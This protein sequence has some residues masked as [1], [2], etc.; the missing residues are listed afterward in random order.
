M[1]TARAVVYLVFACG[2]SGAVAQIPFQTSLHRT[3][4]GKSTWYNAEN[5][6]FETLTGVPIEQMGCRDCHGPTDA[7]GQP[8]PPDYTA[9]CL[10]CHDTAGGVTVAQCLSCHSR[11]GYEINLL[12]F[13]DVHRE[14]G[15]RCWDCHG[16]A[17]LHGDGTE[18]SSMLEPGAIKAECDDCHNGTVM[19]VPHSSPF[20]VNLHDGKLHCTAC[21]AKSV[22]SCYNCHLESQVQAHVKRAKQP[23]ANFV[24][25]VNR[26]KDGKV[27][28]ASFQSLT[29]QGH[30]WV[31]FGPYSP[32]SIVREGRLC[33]ECHNNLSGAVA[34]INEYNARNEMKF[35]TWDDSGKVLNWMRGVVPIPSDYQ[36]K[37]KMDFI[38]YNGAPSDPAAPSTNWSSIGKNTWDGHQMLYASPLTREQ[39]DKLGF[40][41]WATFKLYRT[42]RYETGRLTG[43]GFLTGVIAGSDEMDVTQIALESLRLEGVPVAR[44]VIQDRVAPCEGDDCG[45]VAKRKDGAPDLLLKFR[46]ADLLAVV[47]DYEP[48]Q[49]RVLR[50]TGQ[51]KSGATLTG[52][53]CVVLGKPPK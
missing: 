43:R 17:D 41:R 36:K 39:M 28:P 11:Q 2:L 47:G 31:A 38:A 7:T 33:G 45:C 26:H 21:H 3:R 37:F 42:L 16:Y 50:L 9:G 49:Q 40:T 25:L 4:A 29:Y 18:Y 20:D 19:P 24:L 48:G 22:V 12:K 23:I 46:S 14:A 44:A 6:G 15:F 1:R 52:K 32:H 13:P 30:G 34:A 35:V 27:H 10:D 53:D 8:Y 5:G 51:L